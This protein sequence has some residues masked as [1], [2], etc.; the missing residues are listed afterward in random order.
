MK[1]Y[2]LPNTVNKHRFLFLLSAPLHSHPTGVLFRV[3][4]LLL[5]SSHYAQR[6]VL[7]GLEYKATLSNIIFFFFEKPFQVS[8]LPSRVSPLCCLS[9]PARLPSCKPPI[10]RHCFS[11]PACFSNTT[12]CLQIWVPLA[13]CQAL[14]HSRCSINLDV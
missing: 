2:L 3:L 9:F 11:Q 4:C 10:L 6:L 8:L 13:Q 14:I 12:Q 1:N 5:A 7:F